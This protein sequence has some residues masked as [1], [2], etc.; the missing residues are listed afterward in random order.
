[1]SRVTSGGA[2]LL[3]FVGI[4]R[5]L[6]THPPRAPS[7]FSSCGTEDLRAEGPAPS[8]L[9]GDSVGV[10]EGSAAASGGPNSLQGSRFHVSGF[11]LR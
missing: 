2:A 3:C 9:P 5:L 6:S 4:L 1:M 10:A 11:D 8:T 7:L